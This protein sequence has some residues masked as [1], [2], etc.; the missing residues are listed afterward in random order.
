MSHAA[1]QSCLAHTRLPAYCHH[2]L[3]PGVN[4]P[5]C[6][7]LHRLQPLGTK[8]HL[9]H[10]RLLSRPWST[11]DPAAAAA[12]DDGVCLILAAGIAL[13]AATVFALD[14]AGAMMASLG[15]AEAG[16]LAAAFFNDGEGLL[17]WVLD[18]TATGLC[19]CLDIG[20]AC[21]GNAATRRFAAG[22]AEAD[23]GTDSLTALRGCLIADKLCLAEQLDGS[24]AWLA[25]LALLLGL[26]PEIPAALPA[27]LAFEAEPLAAVLALGC[28]ACLAAVSALG[29]CE[30]LL[31]RP[32]ASAAGGADSA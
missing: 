12:A 22:L 14:M 18:N 4:R 10:P 21:L 24:A 13:G 1:A 31:W 2:F 19:A 17:V 32:A 30:S 23:T 11:S 7:A 26:P 8:R 15:S 5:A 28:R 25:A 9:L 6:F 3:M 27:V 20:A 29:V 16:P